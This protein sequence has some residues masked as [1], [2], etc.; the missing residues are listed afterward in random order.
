MNSRNP[1]L[2]VEDDRV[3]I[4]TI[5]R[6]FAETKVDAPLDITHNGE[7]A[8]EYL[9]NNPRPS[10]IFLDLNMPRMNGMEFLR[11]IKNDNRLSM[12]PVVVLTTSNEK[13]DI[14]ESFRLGAAGYMVKPIDFS[15]FVEMIKVV[16][17]Y[18]TLNVLP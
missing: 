3:D 18:W 1:V 14:E 5:K 15:E 4:L 11:T 9:H 7:E 16:F 8:L 10:L 12:I 2:L 13:R 17:S 6:A